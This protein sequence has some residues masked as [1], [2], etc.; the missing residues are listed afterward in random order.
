M[1]TK[2]EILHVAKLARIR[3]NDEQVEEYRGQIG[4]ILD[5]VMK[6]QSVDTSGVTEAV[7]AVETVNV[8]R[9][10]VVEG[11]SPDEVKRIIEGFPRRQG[12][13]LEV[14]AVFTDRTE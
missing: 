12:D 5:Y 1:V 3:L 14:Q 6:L 4:S 2:E 7:R 11:C 10:D 13:L 9:E 8:F